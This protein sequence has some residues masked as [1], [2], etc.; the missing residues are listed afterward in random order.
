M[1]LQK[2][3]FRAFFLKARVGNECPLNDYLTS[4]QFL[5]FS[6]QFLILFLLIYTNVIF[7]LIYGSKLKKW[8]GD[9]F[10]ELNALGFENIFE[11]GVIEK[12][13]GKH[14]AATFNK[15]CLSLFCLTHIRINNKKLFKVLLNFKIPKLQRQFKKIITEPWNFL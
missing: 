13:T 6:I 3:N 4:F 9:I 15:F 14:K 2:H 1:F 10:V 12:R 5:L 11:V 7:C 8:M